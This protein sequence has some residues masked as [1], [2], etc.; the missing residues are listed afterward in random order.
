MVHVRTQREET[1][2]WQDADPPRA[3][4]THPA[5]ARREERTRTGE[6][7]SQRAGDREVPIVIPAPAHAL[8]CTRSSH[9]VSRA[10][11]S[12]PTDRSLLLTARISHPRVAADIRALSGA[13]TTPSVY[14]PFLS[15]CSVPS[16][17]RSSLRRH[18][19]RVLQ[20]PVAERHGGAERADRDREPASAAQ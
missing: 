17:A 3:T 16:S 7:G 10:L 20:Q 18:V 13:S 4:H 8:S 11:I 5:A 14:L 2:R 9:R 12:P 15:S 19:A 1:I 6:D